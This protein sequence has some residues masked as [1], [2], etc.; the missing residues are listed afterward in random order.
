M[1]T[2]IRRKVD[3]LGRVVIPAGIRRSLG[4]REG[5]ALEVHVDGEQVILAKPSDQ[6]VFCGAEDGLVEFRSR[7]VCRSCIEGMGG[8]GPDAE[9]GAS[10]G[11]PSDE[12]A[13]PTSEEPARPT[14]DP[15]TREPGPLTVVRDDAPA[16][17][18]GPSSEPARDPTTAW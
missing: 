5:D 3:D 10:R 9:R 2:G 8:L 7:N 13:R 1:R 17:Q 14:R 15:A 11:W 18:E 16:G 6:C 12:P 4:I